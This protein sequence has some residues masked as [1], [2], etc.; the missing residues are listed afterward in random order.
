MIDPHQETI[1]AIVAR[2]PDWMRQ[3]LLSKDPIV[4]RRAEE[5]LAAMITNAFSDVR[6]DE[7]GEQAAA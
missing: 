4:R 7:G 2:A 6:E 1:T 5:T 3:D